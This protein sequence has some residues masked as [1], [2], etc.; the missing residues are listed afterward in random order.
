MTRNYRSAQSYRNAY[1]S[2]PHNIATSAPA[3]FDAPVYSLGTYLAAVAEVIR[4]KG[5]FK[6]MCAAD[7]FELV[8][9]NKDGNHEFTVED[10]ITAANAVGWINTKDVRP[11]FESDLQAAVGMTDIPQNKMRLVMY[12]V[13]MYVEAQAPAVGSESVH[14]GSV[15]ERVTLVV[16]VLEA[17]WTDSMYGPSYRTKAVTAEGNVVMF[18]FKQE[19]SGQVKITGTITKHTTFNNVKETCVNRVKVGA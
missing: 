8:I 3:R 4:T 7:A 16:N 18:Y 13:K 19:L 6:E 11:G 9:A 14:F 5:F 17:V 1:Y 15:G 10:W 12:V 2:R